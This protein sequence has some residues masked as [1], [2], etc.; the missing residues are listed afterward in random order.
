MRTLY[1]HTYTKIRAF[2]AWTT[3]CMS[4]VIRSVTQQHGLGSLPRLSPTA[5]LP[6][7]PSCQALE[8]PSLRKRSALCSL[9]DQPWRAGAPDHQQQVQR[10]EGEGEHSRGW[11]Q[12]PGQPSR[13]WSHQTVPLKAR[14]K[15]DLRYETK[16]LDCAGW[17]LRVTKSQ[18]LRSFWRTQLNVRLLIGRPGSVNQLVGG[19]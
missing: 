19:A 1:I 18:P 2:V 8:A 13:T 3:S 10:R 14:S 9:R 4:M 15:S 12:G 17:E 11:F 5:T 7:L 6:C 16:E